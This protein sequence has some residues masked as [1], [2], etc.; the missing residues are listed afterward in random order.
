[1][2]YC[3]HANELHAFS[4]EMDPKFRLVHVVYSRVTAKHCIL[5]P[6]SL[7]TGVQNPT[8]TQKTAPVPSVH[9]NACHLDQFYTY[10]LLYCRIW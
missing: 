2:K 9:F 1:V 7:I 8:N 3:Q 6:E 10:V 5:K 4:Q